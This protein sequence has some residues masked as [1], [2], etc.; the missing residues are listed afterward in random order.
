[1]CSVERYI[2]KRFSYVRIGFSSIT[3][4][5]ERREGRV[6]VPE[7]M[8]NGELASLWVDRA[9]T[10]TAVSSSSSSLGQVWALGSL[11]GADD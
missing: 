1:M 5:K 2:A 6:E 9:E 8:L 11:R 4:R 3:L 10:C 7:Q